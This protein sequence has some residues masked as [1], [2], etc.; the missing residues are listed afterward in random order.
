MIETERDGPTRV[1]AVL[2]G[3]VLPGVMD[4]V[5]DEEGTRIYVHATPALVEELR[6]EIGGD[7]Q[8]ARLP[9]GAACVQS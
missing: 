3:V 9:D 6:Q 1:R 5:H 2:V 4:E 8:R 7:D